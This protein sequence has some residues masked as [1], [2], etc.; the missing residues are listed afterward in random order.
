MNLPKRATLLVLL[1]TFLLAGGG[2]YLF[3]RTPRKQEESPSSWSEQVQEG[4]LLQAPFE[5]LITLSEKLEN[6][7]FLVFR[8]ADESVILEMTFPAGEVFD[9]GKRIMEKGELL[10]R[11][12]EGTLEIK[13][14]KGSFKIVPEDLLLKTTD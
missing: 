14:A 2:V 5:G 7:H 6:F 1:F 4:T 13:V 12:G 9:Q 10:A 8:G 3:L 11:L